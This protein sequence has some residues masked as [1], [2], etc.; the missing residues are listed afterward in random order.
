MT[1]FAAFATDDDQLLDGD[2]IAT[3]GGWLHFAEWAG[4]LGDD[5]PL[6]A[7]LCEEGTADDLQA[8][9]QELERALGE[10]PGKPSREVLAVGR[11]LLAVL[12]DAPEGAVALAVTDGTEPEEGEEEEGEGD[13]L[14]NDGADAG[15]PGE[16]VEDEEDQYQ[17]LEGVQVKGASCS[18]GPGCSCTPCRSKA[19]EDEGEC[20]RLQK[21]MLDLDDAIGFIHAALKT[22]EAVGGIQKALSALA[23]GSGGAIVAP[24]AQGRKD[25]LNGEFEAELREKLVELTE[26][27]ERL[28]TELCD[29]C[30]ICETSEG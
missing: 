21:E 19:L 25:H 8:L 4:A 6:L 10:K 15:P 11:R 29:R 27:R 28:R 5:F 14:D 16:E 9:E 26:R 2:D 23:E 7:E 30:G 22:G 3:S 1:L 18:C 17:A 24:A 13:D 12:S 20:R